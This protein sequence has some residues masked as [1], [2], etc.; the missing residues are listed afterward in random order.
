MVQ[1]EKTIA[2]IFYKHFKPIIW[3]VI[4]LVF[5]FF[6]FGVVLAWWGWVPPSETNKLGDLGNYGSF[7]Q[8]TTATCWAMTGVLLVA[9]AFFAQ[10]YQILD[11]KVN[12]DKQMKEQ[13]GREGA[14]KGFEQELTE[15]TEGDRHEQTGWNPEVWVCAN[16]ASGNRGADA[17]LWRD[18]QRLQRWVR[19]A[20]T[21]HGIGTIPL[22]GDGNGLEVLLCASHEL[23]ACSSGRNVS[24]KGPF[25]DPFM[26][27]EAQAVDKRTMLRLHPFPDRPLRDSTMDR[28]IVCFSPLLTNW[29]II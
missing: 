14:K 7:L 5:F 1:R 24:R 12:I 26:K 18:K 2:D 17:G 23:P 9:A 27:P 15:E 6:G 4:A 29:N 8:G 25:D 28:L 11:Q 19:A 20:A 13:Q 3:G 22:F 16:V 10:L 21:R